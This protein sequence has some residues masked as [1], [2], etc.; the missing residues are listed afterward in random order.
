MASTYNIISRTVL[1]SGASTITF[2]AIPATY[3]DLRLVINYKLDT[4]YAMQFQFN[5]DTATN[6]STTILYGNGSSAGSGRYSQ[7][8]CK[9]ADNVD[10]VWALGTIDV[11][12]Y[13]GST[14]KTSL[15]TNSADNNGSGW[16]ERNV[17]LWRSTAAIT[18]LKVGSIGASYL[19]IAGTTATLYGIKAA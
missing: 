16:I 17:G 11:F 13:A 1:A 6:Y 18:S 12:S 10:S 8:F 5:A 3:T 14:Y 4:A 9:I 19:M 2:S 15:M 7:A